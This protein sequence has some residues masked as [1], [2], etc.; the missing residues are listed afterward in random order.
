VVT[1]LVSLTRRA[2]HSYVWLDMFKNRNTA[3]TMI[4][5]ALPKNVTL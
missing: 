1:F 4:N 3:G 5:L 2:R